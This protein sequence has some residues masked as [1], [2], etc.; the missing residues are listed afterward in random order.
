MHMTQVLR[1]SADSIIDIGAMSPHVASPV[2]CRHGNGE[3]AVFWTVPDGWRAFS[4]SV[5]GGGIVDQPRWVVNASVDRDY[6]RSDPQA[7]LGEIAAHFGFDGHG[8]GLITA[9]DVRKAITVT[10]DGAVVT[11]TV[12]VRQPT[13][14]DLVDLTALEAAPASPKEP[15]TIN[16]VAWLPAVFNNAALLNLLVT[17]TEAKVAALHQVGI[18]NPP[19]GS[20]ALCLLSYQ[21]GMHDAAGSTEEYGGPRSTWG[22]RLSRALTETIVAAHERAH[23]PARS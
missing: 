15:G 19:M 1:P 2:H 3:S 8:I 7:H 23:E 22:A 16:T 9:V 14:D 20:D 10:V 11:S 18:D 17:A 4:T 5:H 13:E 21:P 6:R 12:G